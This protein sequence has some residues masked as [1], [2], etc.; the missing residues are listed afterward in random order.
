MVRRWH[1]DPFG[2]VRPWNEVPAIMGSAPPAT[3]PPPAM[4]VVTFLM[5]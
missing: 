2:F 5:G 3:T 4:G 1:T